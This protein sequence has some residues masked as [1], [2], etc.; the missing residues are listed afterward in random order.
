MKEQFGLCSLAILV[1]SSFASAMEPK[2]LPGLTRDE[3]AIFDKGLDAFSEENSV[4]GEEP[5]APDAGLGPRFNGTS[6]VSCHG[7]PFAGGTSP[8]I[9]PQIEQA[10]RFGARNKVP[11]FLSANGPVR[12]V[13][14][15]FNRDGSRDG[16]V[17]ALFTVTGRKD[18]GKCDIAQPD[19]ES[20]LRRNNLAF[21]IPTPVLGAG[22]IEA[23]PDR[24]IIENMNANAARRRQL[25]IS[26][27]E[28][29]NGND[30]TISRFGWKAQ[31]KS[32]LLFAAEA[33]NVE[34]GVT[35]EIF[36]T[37][38]EEDSVCHVSPSPE[39]RTHPEAV[40]LADGLSDA[41][42]FSLFMKFLAPP[43]PQQTLNARFPSSDV[44]KQG[45]QLFNTIGCAECHTPTLMTGIASTAALSLKPAN[46][47]SDLLVHH[48]GPDL[49]DEV[50]QGNA[51][52]GEFRTAPLW[53]LG[54]RLFFL[55][56]GRTSDLTQAVLA[57][58]SGVVPCS[59]N[60]KQVSSSCASEANAVVAN[61]RSLQPQQK[62]A[63]LSFLKSL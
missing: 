18:A 19:F 13:R 44:L 36:Q 42:L 45:R 5:G 33:Y 24:V 21:R 1:L 49:A 20:E 22:L 48:M 30:G 4:L 35:N 59:R 60:I 8:E 12:E 11:S 10:T 57:H 61:F 14:F 58:A 17:H 52:P 51:G 50:I 38:R 27:H 2:A 34:Q 40:R 63:L 26:G 16:G 7:H 29:R 46:L 3:L 28:N 23:I 6:C 15:K 54:Q 32:L 31:N 55:H 41:V 9:N 25:G 37:E 56:D 47:Y 39:D 53:G 62:S 43:Q